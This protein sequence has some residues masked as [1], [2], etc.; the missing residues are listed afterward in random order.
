MSLYVGNLTQSIK[1]KDLQEAF[2]E[3]GPCKIKIISSFAFVEFDEIRDAEDALQNMQG[4]NIAGNQV[5][6]EWSAKS[7]KNLERKERKRECFICGSERHKKIDCP[8]RTKYRRRSRSRSRSRRRSER[9]R[10][11]RSRSRSRNNRRSK[12][13]KRKY[14]RS[15]SRSSRSRSR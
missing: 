12:D 1:L 8:Q 11:H 6:I 3:F 9:K 13:K 7:G 5:K 15:S 4:K 14:S 2:E 10:R